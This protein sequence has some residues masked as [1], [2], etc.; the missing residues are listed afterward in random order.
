MAI[1][2][3]HIA[4]APHATPAAG[5]DRQIQIAAKQLAGHFTVDVR[6]VLHTL[7]GLVAVVYPPRD[8]N[9]EATPTCGVNAKAVQVDATLL[10]VIQKLV[11]IVDAVSKLVSGLTVPVE[12]QIAAVLGLLHLFWRTFI[13]DVRIHLKCRD[14][15]RLLTSSHIGSLV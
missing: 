4:S 15:R 6:Q 5:V 3:L 12:V 13:R 1:V 2:T 9:V 11:H 7:V 14:K 10:Q 8:F